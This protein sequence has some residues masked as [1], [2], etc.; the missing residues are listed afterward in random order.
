MF[1]SP[2]IAGNTLYIG[3]HEGKFMAIDL[4][5]QKVAWTFQTDGSRKNG[6]TYTK[7]DGSP[8]YEVAFEDDFYDDMIVGVRKMLSVGAVLSSPAVVEDVVYLRKQRWQS[9]CLDVGGWKFFTERL[10]M[11]HA[12]RRL[13]ENTGIHASCAC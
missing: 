7:P 8:N 1:S 6:P 9:V 5:A 2:A 3:S 10:S 11:R 13:I 12:I 4:T